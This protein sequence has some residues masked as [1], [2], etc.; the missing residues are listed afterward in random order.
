MNDS[1]PNGK[2]SWVRID[3]GALRR[4]VE[5]C[6]DLAGEACGIM[7]I[8]KAD[9]Y[10][11]GLSAVV[12]VIQDEVSWFGTANLKE[13]E[14]ILETVG[15]GGTHIVVLCPLMPD[16]RKAAIDR[17]ISVSVSN[18]GEIDGL[19]RAASEVGK[20]ARIHLSVDTGMGRTGVLPVRFPEMLDCIKKAKNCQLEGV[21]SH[22]P[23]ADEEREFTLQ[24]I[25]EFRDLVSGVTDCH[26]HM[27]NSAGLLGYQEQL[28][29]ASLARPG[30]ALYGVSPLEGQGSAL[31]PV[32]TWKTR[33][34]LVREIPRGHSISY[35]RSFV[36]QRPMKTAT[37]AVGYGDGY[38]RSLSHRNADV[39]IAGSRCPLLGRVT[40]DQIVVDVS[41]LSENVACGDEAVLLGRQGEQEISA[42]ELAEKA[43]TISWEI[44]TGIGSRVERCYS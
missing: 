12:K 22:F 8:V 27:A 37:L 24:Q 3:I 11:H 39:L 31:C 13:A 20:K 43:S 7:A 29:F 42:A 21:W 25:S 14:E 4:N 32:L 44:F 10:G 15:T 26:I 38:P 28:E 17:G 34:A 2:R 1:S 19:E 16:E 35:G 6:R 41:H 5:V 9:A 36:S 30:L 18:A 33:V 40:M 23:S